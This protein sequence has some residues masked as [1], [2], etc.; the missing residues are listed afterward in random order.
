MDGPESLVPTPWQDRYY[1]I[2]YSKCVHFVQTLYL[3]VEGQNDT[4]QFR[5]PLPIFC[6][7][8]LKLIMGINSRAKA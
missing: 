6:P 7:R 1:F 4:D 5:I 3:A 8:P 2:T